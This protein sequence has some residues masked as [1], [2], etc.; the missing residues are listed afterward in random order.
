MP[1][2]YRR[3]GSILLAALL[4]LGAAVTR[5]E[6]RYQ[7]LVEISSSVPSQAQIFFDVGHGYREEDSS[8]QAITAPSPGGFQ[9]LAFPLPTATIYSLRF[10]PLNSAGRIVI[11]DIHIQSRQRTVFRFSPSDVQPLNQIASE[12]TRG[13]QLDARTTPAATDPSLRLVLRQPLPLKRVSLREK[14]RTFAIGAVALSF[15]AFLSLAFYEQLQFFISRLLAASRTFLKLRTARYSSAVLP[16][17]SLAIWFYVACAVLFLAASVLNLNGSSI[18]FYSV[19]Y[20]HGAHVK[21]WTG[22]P[23]AIRSD[24]WGYHTPDVL[25]QAFRSDRFAVQ[26]SDLG[27]HSAALIG[28]VP[29][30]DVSTLFRPQFWTFFVLP[31]EYAFAF[32]WQCKA[33]FLVA[34]VFTWLLF[35]TRSSSWAIVGALWF[36]F[37]PFTQWS[38]SWPSALPEMIGLAC[39]STVLLCYL[40]V[41]QNRVALAASAIGFAICAIDFALCAYVPHMIPI[42]WVN[43]AVLIA[44]CIANRTLILTRP[45]LASRI[46]ALSLSFLVMAAVGIHVY[47]QLQHTLSAVSQTVYPGKRVVAGGSLPFWE[48]LSHFMQWTETEDRFPA[49]IGNLSEGSGFL[50]LAPFAILCLS[51]L[52]LDRTHRALLISLYVCFFAILAWITLPIPASVGHIFAFDKVPAARAMPALGLAN[53]GVVTLCASLLKPWSGRIKTAYKLLLAG[54][55]FGISA[56]VFIAINVKLDHFFSR[57]ELL[58]IAAFTTFLIIA[59]ITG[60]GASLMFGL[61]AANIIY[62]GN[63]NPIERGL[64]VITNSSLFG[65]VQSHRTLLDGKWLVFSDT[66]VGTGFLAA[67]GF[68][69]YTGTHYC[70]DIDHFPVFRQYHLDTAILNRLG[71][72]DAHPLKPGQTSTVTLDNPV[73]VRWNVSPTAPILKGIGI[74]Y[75]AF[76]AM[77]SPVVSD[78]LIP[79]SNGAIDGFWLY[80]IP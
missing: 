72:L 69:V 61:V 10:D 74:K 8:T 75:V 67:M 36:F 9:Q 56:L 13:D 41:G 57:L 78:G 38:Y 11:R 40:L 20:G 49:A 26:D 76:D 43:F 27:P 42:F 47:L 23:R 68:Q 65:F 30:R 35:I 31:V 34:G 16:L 5:R 46:V 29:V 50:W 73:V 60:Q 44:W 15:I 58:L 63:V 2:P 14:T 22:G 12:Q 51:K 39:F 37:S 7:L 28:N 6:A 21:T 3:V 53:V 45:G 71:Y 1:R 79:V 4:V 80:R 52:R 18:S 17:D 64:P 55:V 54:S 24:E 25:S 77:A 70:P 66:P 62:F 33:L 48:L 59:F 32:Y 19:A